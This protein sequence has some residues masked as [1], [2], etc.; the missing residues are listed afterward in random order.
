MISNILE[1][2]G[3]VAIVIGVSIMLITLIPVSAY[4]IGHV[5]YDCLHVNLR[6]VHQHRRYLKLV[7]MPFKSFVTGFVDGLWNPVTSSRSS[8]WIWYPPF[9]FVKVLPRATFV[10]GE[11]NDD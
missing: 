2:I 10:L 1:N 11:H 3:L 4:A 9:G 8:K 6:Y 5:I 7:I